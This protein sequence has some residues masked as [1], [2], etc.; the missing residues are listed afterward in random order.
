[1]RPYIRLV[2]SKIN[3]HTQRWSLFVH[4]S[5]SCAAAVSPNV[6][7]NLGRRRRAPAHCGYQGCTTQAS[8]VGT[9]D[10]SKADQSSLGRRKGGSRSIGPAFEW[11]GARQARALYTP[12]TVDTHRIGHRTLHE[13]KPL[14]PNKHT[15]A[16]RSHRTF[17]LSLSFLLSCAQA[18]EGR[19]TSHH[20]AA[21]RPPTRPPFPRLPRLVLSFLFVCP[22]VRFTECAS[23]PLS[24]PANVVSSCAGFPP[25]ILL[26]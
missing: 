5:A 21:A 16:K 20:L 13:K 17:F 1:M 9:H 25:T 15:K 7:S 11:G 12:T 23:S 18:R 4:I 14:P 24:I 19:N 6:C 22:V 26:E 3:S 10:R 2:T 8:A